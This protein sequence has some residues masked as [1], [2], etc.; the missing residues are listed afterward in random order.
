M[1]SDEAHHPGN[2]QLEEHDAA[3]QL[4]AA[5]FPADRRDRRGT[6]HIQQAEYHERVG[7]GRAE[8][9][10]CKHCHKAV[11]PVGCGNILDAEKHAAARHHHFFRRDTGDQRHHNL[12]V[13]QAQ[14]LKNGTI[15]LPTTDPKLSL[16][17]VTY[18][19]V[20]KFS[21]AHMIMD[22]RKITVPAFVR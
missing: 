10:G 8:S 14:R 18:P 20:P 13:S 2:S 16:I 1:E 9:H 12:P 17:S 15:S 4:R 7:I 22:A 21:S 3:C 5:H 19:V 6:G 11:H